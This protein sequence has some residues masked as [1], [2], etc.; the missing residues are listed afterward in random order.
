MTADALASAHGEERLMALLQESLAAATRLGG[1]QTGRLPC[2]DRRTT[3]QEKAITF[4]TD[5]KLMHRARE[6]L[7]KLAKKTA[8]A[9]A[10]PMRGS[11]SSR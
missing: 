3:V 8:S 4:P 10:S 11:G 6:R 1:G 9:C 2:G 5:A 7:V